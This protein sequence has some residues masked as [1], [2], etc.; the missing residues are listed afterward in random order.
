M[1]PPSDGM[2]AQLHEGRAPDA[3]QRADRGGEADRLAEVAPPVLGREVSISR[4]AA[5]HGRHER[6]RRRAM[7]GGRRAP[8]RAARA[9]DPSGG[10]GTRSSRRATGR[11]RLVARGRR[12]RSRARRRRPPGP[13]W[14]G[15]LTAAMPIRSLAAA[16]A[17][18][19]S[20]S[21]S[22]TE[23]IRPRPSARCMRRARWTTTRTASASVRG[24]RHV[25]G[26]DLAD[27][28]AGDGGRARCPTTSAARRARPGARRWPAGRT[29][30]APSRALV[31]AG[32]EQVE[33][34]PAGLGADQ[35]VALL[36]QP[37]GTR[38][39]ARAA[40]V[41]SRATGRPA[42]RRRRRARRPRRRRQA[43]RPAPRPR[44]A[45]RPARRARRRPRPRGADSGCG[46]RAAEAQRSSRSSVCAP[47]CELLLVRAR[48][49]P[50][51]VVPTRGE[52]QQMRAARGAVGRRARRGGASSITTCALL[53]PKPNALTPP[54][55]RAVAARPR[56]QRRGDHEGACR[57]GRRGDSARESGR[58]RAPPRAAAT[59]RP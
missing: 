29:R 36:D 44:R 43:R 41:P 50:Q 52:R 56:L 21:G 3:G 40:R 10:C 38:A 53:P 18:S 11:P 9:A 12:R 34:R 4:R 5:G 24:A 55:R 19:A 25:R 46:A 15:A 32:A 14:S 13:S 8:R 42:R 57:R 17:R 6:K 2:R 20:A 7:D 54:Q 27:A 45:E 49:G 39:R 23:T 47:S 35:L 51:A 58:A 31:L 48:Q 16:M 37:G 28:V 59:A 1:A 22:S 33:H 30:C 26:G